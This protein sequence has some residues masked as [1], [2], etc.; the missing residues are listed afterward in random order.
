MPGPPARTLVPDHDDVAGLM[1]PWVTASIASFSPSKTRAV[2]SNT[3][4]VEAGALDHGALRRE[5]AAQ[6]R[7]AAGA[8]DRVGQRVDDLAVRVRRGDV[9]EVLGHRAA[10]H[11]E[12]VA[13][14]QP[15]VEQRLH[16]HRDA[17]DRGRCR[18]SRTG[19]TA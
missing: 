11:G 6:D 14:Q 16:D 1:R 7:Q 10:G 17:A 8:V 4:A 18:S 3:L 9:G 2:P 15:G 5:R 13:V 19:R 12:R